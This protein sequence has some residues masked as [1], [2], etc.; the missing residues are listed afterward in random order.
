MPQK[1]NQTN[2]RRGL[3]ESYTLEMTQHQKKQ[4]SEQTA[5]EVRQD[6]EKVLFWLDVFST[7]W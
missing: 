3:H 4:L 7:S 2:R 5:A 1:E 6:F